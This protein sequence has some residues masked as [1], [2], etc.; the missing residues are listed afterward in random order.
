LLLLLLPF[1]N[2]LL[3]RNTHAAAGDHPPCFIITLLT[4]LQPLL[5][6]APL[7]NDS[8]PVRGARFG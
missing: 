3:L 6:H 4:S 5:T 8:A 1:R 2:D 7:G